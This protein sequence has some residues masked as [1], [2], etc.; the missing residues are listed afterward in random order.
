V[1]SIAKGASN[2]SVFS[3]GGDQYI[4]QWDF[5][6]GKQMPFAAKLSSACYAVI[7]IEKYH[8]LVAGT[9]TGDFH[10]IDFFNRIELKHLLHHSSGVYDLVFNETDNQ[11]LVAGGDGVLSVWSLPDF[12]LIRSIPLCEGKLRQIALTG[13]N[14]MLAIACGDGHVRVLDPIFFN[15][16]ATIVA[17]AEGATS[18]A[19]H[20]SK[21]VLM[22]GGKDAMLR[23]WNVNEN[24]REIASLAAHLST[25]YTIR[26]H[27]DQPIFATASRDKT[28]KI[29]D[30]QTLAPLARVDTGAHGHTHSVNKV[31]WMGNALISCS[32]DRRIAT[33]LLET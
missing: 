21:P 2:T 1:Y 30:A 13:D 15:E 8:L 27:E 31:L 29:W 18:V 12:K 17:H 26:F 4:A 16:M 11:L 6:S 10:V 22:S 24:Y 14:S 9:S 25:I 7:Y 5:M 3:G 28:I 23:S 33:F 19:W 20:P 32:D